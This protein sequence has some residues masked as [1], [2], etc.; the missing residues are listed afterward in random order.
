[1]SSTFQRQKGFDG[2]LSTLDADIQVLGHAK[3]TCGIPPAQG[4]FDSTGALL[5][6]IRVRSLPLCCFELY[7][8]GF[9]QDPMFN[10][11]DY[12]DLGKLCAGVCKALDRGSKGRR[13]DELSPSVLDA[14]ELLTTWVEPAM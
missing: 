3:D 5:T 14:I 4:A 9:L 11:Q 7:A 8:H 1:M 13:L 2:V 10:K 6:T 12:V